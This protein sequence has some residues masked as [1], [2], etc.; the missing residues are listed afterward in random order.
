M[1]SSALMNETTG[2][3]EMLVHMYQTTRPHSRYSAILV[4]SMCR[5]HCETGKGLLAQLDPVSILIPQLLQLYQ[6]TAS[7]YYLHFKL[8]AA[9]SVTVSDQKWMMIPSPTQR[10]WG[11]NE[12]TPASLITVIKILHANWIELQCFR[13]SIT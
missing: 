12:S 2:S 6:H 3:S 4:S 1:N 7:I 13:Y 10:E 11:T 5:K 8:W 9:A